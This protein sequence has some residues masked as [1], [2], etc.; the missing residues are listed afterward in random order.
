MKPELRISI[1]DGRRNK[2]LKILLSLA[3][4]DVRRFTVRI[5][6]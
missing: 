3:P 5:N 1:K 6:G 2:N 4:L